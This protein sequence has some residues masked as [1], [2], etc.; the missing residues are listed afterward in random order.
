M[1]GKY[2]RSFDN[3]ELIKEIAI[4]NLISIYNSDLFKDL[5]ASVRKNIEDTLSLY[6]EKC[7]KAALEDLDNKQRTLH[8]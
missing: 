1:Y 3:K 6:A 4:S 7:S 2:E 8:L 5:D